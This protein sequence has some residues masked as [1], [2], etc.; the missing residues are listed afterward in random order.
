MHDLTLAAF[1]FLASLAASES[2]RDRRI[3]LRVAS[4]HFVQSRPSDPEAIERFADAMASRLNAADAVTRLEIARKLAPCGQTPLRLLS[5]FESVDSEAGDYVLQHA[6]AYNHRVLAQAVARGNRRPIAVA[7]RRKL[8]PRLV[9]ILAEQDDIDVLVALAGNDSAPLEGA[10]LA[11]LLRLAR[12]Q[13]EEESDHRLA[14]ALLQRRPVRPE[15]A[16]LFLSAKPNQ[17]VEI[18]LAVQRTQLGRP[19]G[20][21]LAAGPNKLDEMELAAVARQPDRFVVI[22]AEALDC[23]LGLAQRIGRPVRRAS[24]GRPGGPR[25]GE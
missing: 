17:R 19:P 6:V 22:L 16:A 1:P 20:S 25:R 2:A 13:A 21:L 12:R 10:T 4:D 7:R 14:D 5:L 23:E 3:W 18:L 8:D 15:N 11:H 9:G 24:R